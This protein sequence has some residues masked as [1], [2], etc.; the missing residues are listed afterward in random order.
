[1][2]AYR[3]LGS[4]EDAEDAVQETFCA[5]GGAATPSTARRPISAWLYR[6]ATNVC[7]DADPAREPA[8]SK[9]RTLSSLGEVPWL[10]P[11][12]D[13]LLDERTA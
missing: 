6:I 7:L 12:P 3:M 10:Q 8:G 5:R 11:F 2:H 13:R 9:A 4:F 1:M